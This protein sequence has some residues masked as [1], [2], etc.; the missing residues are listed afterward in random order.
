M[1][2]MADRAGK[3]PLT[4]FAL[5]LPD[6][7]NVHNATRPHQTVCY[8]LRPLRLTAPRTFLYYTT[9][10]MVSLLVMVHKSVKMDFDD[11]PPRS[12]VDDGHLQRS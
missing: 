3:Y 11:G 6:P 9:E 4:I 2:E 7:Y 1:R 5:V 12:V 10:A 8:V